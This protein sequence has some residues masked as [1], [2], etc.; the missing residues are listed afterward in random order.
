MNSDEEEK[1]ER[2]PVRKFRARRNT[3][4]VKA[5]AEERLPCILRVKRKLD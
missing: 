3:D 4:P 5:I 1:V 2:K